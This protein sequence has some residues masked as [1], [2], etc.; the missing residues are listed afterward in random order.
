MCVA[1]L[2][3]STETSLWTHYSAG[4]REYCGNRFP[5]GLRKNDRSGSS[6]RPA[7]ITR[8]AVGPGLWQGIAFPARSIT[9]LMLSTE[10]HIREAQEYRGGSGD[11][12]MSAGCCAGWKPMW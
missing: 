5:D 1:F 3:G 12:M 4:E 10:E 6:P 9:Q 2:A 7:G 11:I 8:A